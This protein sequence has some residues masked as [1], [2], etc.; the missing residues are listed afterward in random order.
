LASFYCADPPLHSIPVHPVQNNHTRMSIQPFLPTSPTASRIHYL[1]IWIKLSRHLPPFDSCVLSLVP[2]FVLLVSETPIRRR[3]T[4]VRVAS[5]DLLVLFSCPG[6]DRAELPP[7]C[8]PSCSISD[9]P[10]FHFSLGTA[11]NNLST[12]QYRHQ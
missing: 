9:A 7:A 3:G 2:D 6:L 10:F 12:T 8:V 5:V 11:P 4:A 1:Q